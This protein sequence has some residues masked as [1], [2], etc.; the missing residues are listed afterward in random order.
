LI[1]PGKAS[2]F[3]LSG[4][5]LISL[6]HIKVLNSPALFTRSIDGV[7]FNMP[8]TS[9]NTRRRTT[10]NNDRAL[11][12][13]VQPVVAAQELDVY[14]VIRSF[15]LSSLDDKIFPDYVDFLEAPARIPNH[16]RVEW[17]KVC[18]T[19]SL[20]KSW[21]EEGRP[22]IVSMDGT[23]FPGT[24]HLRVVEQV[25]EELQQ[26]ADAIFWQVEAFK[27]RNKAVAG[28][29]IR[30]CIQDGDWLNLA[31]LLTIDCRYM[32]G[33]REQ[34]QGI[35]VTSGMP[36]C[37]AIVELVCKY[38]VMIVDKKEGVEYLTT[39]ARGKEGVFDLSTPFFDVLQRRG[40]KQQR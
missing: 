12:S 5:E 18:E 7:T 23:E 28:R 9:R 22:Q 20:Q 30:K 33:D 10:R 8:V 40:K 27:G 17:R 21:W 1:L 11:A 26:S 4:F 25:A 14:T 35:A 15:A 16:Q 31:E 38:F 39:G 36:V 2:G 6:L 29:R 24:D 13:R 32:H 34:E 37:D 19:I 3:F